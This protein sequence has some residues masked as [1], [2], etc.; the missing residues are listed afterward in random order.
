MLKRTG[1][2]QLEESAYMFS[3][4]AVNKKEQRS[5]MPKSLDDRRITALL[6]FIAG[7]PHHRSTLRISTD[8]SVTIMLATLALSELSDANHA[9]RAR[10]RIVL[11]AVPA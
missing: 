5:T 10:H 9:M 1:N 11:E 3:L 6:S 2:S 4:C 8:T 7:W